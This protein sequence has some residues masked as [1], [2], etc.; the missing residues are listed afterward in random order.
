MAP[1]LCPDFAS[2]YLSTTATDPL[3]H[4]PPQFFCL[5]FSLS[6]QSMCFSGFLVCLSGSPLP[7][8]DVSPRPPPPPP[9]CGSAFPAV[10]P[11]H[12]S[13]EMNMSP[14]WMLRPEPGD[15]ARTASRNFFMH[16]EEMVMRAFALLHGK[17]CVSGL[18]SE[19]ARVARA[20]ES[21]QWAPGLVAAAGPQRDGGCSAPGRK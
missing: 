1:S 8:Q 9:L 10:P 2:F 19:P 5:S 4:P 3:L 18:N 20:P 7:L 12:P 6:S 16:I 15:G 13:W 21:P 11:P 17:D 14:Y